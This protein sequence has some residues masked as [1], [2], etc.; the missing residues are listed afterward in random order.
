[1]LKRIDSKVSNMA[2]CATNGAPKSLTYA[3]PFELKDAVTGFT[4]RSERIT[5]R[6]VEVDKQIK[7]LGT[8]MEATKLKPFVATISSAPNDGMAQ[9]LGLV[10]MSQWFQN[11]LNVRW[12][13][14]YANSKP[15]RTRTDAIIFSNVPSNLTDYKLEK[16]RDFLEYNSD[17][18]RIICITG[19]DPISFMSDR[20]LYRTNYSILLKTKEVQGVYL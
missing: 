11:G 17:K 9:Q 13:T 18:A 15:H 7:D 12:E 8:I 16:L 1:M 6:Y 20:L 14:L 2:L 4:T 10:L 3:A 19:D 5:K